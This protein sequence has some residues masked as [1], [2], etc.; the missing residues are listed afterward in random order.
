[1]VQTLASQG[2]LDIVGG[3]AHGPR[4]DACARA[5]SLSS[6]RDGGIMVPCSLLFKMEGPW[7]WLI[8]LFHSALTRL[9]PPGG[10]VPADQNLKL[11]C[12]F[13]FVCSISELG[14]SLFDND[15]SDVSDLLKMKQKHFSVIKLKS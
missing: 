5:R 3:P 1:M 2:I 7:L 14:V 11:K 13:D 12:S 8:P 10:V 15:I 6:H 4:V 9:P